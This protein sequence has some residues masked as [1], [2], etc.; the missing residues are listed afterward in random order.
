M[1]GGPIFPQSAYP[2]TSGRV[3]PNVHVGAGANSKHDEGLGVEASVGADSIWRLR[4]QMPPTLPTG[5]GKLRLLMLANAT[6]GDAKINPK[7]VSVAVAED[8]SSATPVAETV[9]TVT[10]AAGDNDDYKELKVT[11]DAD[12]LIGGEVVAMDLT[13]ETA[14]W[15]LAQVLTVIPSIIWE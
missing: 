2:V 14:S 11:L 10:W 8:P 13:F 7:W 1:A 3:F 9:Q 15:T 12:T 5:T 4:F 6:S